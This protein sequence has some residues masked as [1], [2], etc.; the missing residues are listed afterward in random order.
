MVSMT[1]LN[2]GLVREQFEKHTQSTF[3]SLL[4]QPD[5]ADVTLV[6]EDEKQIEAHKVILGAGSDFF[7]GLFL[8][9]PH[10]K[11]LL[12]LKVSHR[13]L[14]EVVNFLYL[15]EC[16]VGQHEVE[17]FLEMA[18]SLQ[19]SGL[20]ADIEDQFIDEREQQK[21][22]SVENTDKEQKFTENRVK[23]EN[24][25]KFGIEKEMKTE[26]CLEDQ[27][28]LC[29][30]CSK[31]LSTKQSLKNHMRSVHQS[32]K[33]DSD[34]LHYPSDEDE[35]MLF[36]DEKSMVSMYR[37]QQAHDKHNFAFRRIQAKTSGTN[38]YKCHSRTCPVRVATREG[39][40]L[41][42]RR[43]HNHQPMPDMI[44]VRRLEAEMMEEIL[45]DPSTAH[46]KLLMSSISDKILT[47][48]M[49][50]FASSFGSLE[51]KLKR[52]LTK[53]EELVVEDEPILI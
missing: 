9:N 12:F 24:A 32:P 17:K 5:F 1:G 44:K 31:T 27:K 14:Q 52:R 39:R 10:P 51:K 8:R 34:D 36:F 4:D 30:I 15:G 46:V 37:G 11:P 21:E 50:L 40:I 53:L 48:E 23:R 16:K 43:S 13:H 28:N 20:N 7:K 45:K 25:A 47:P 19:I 35:E 42:R 41:Y 18:K 26:P 33:K 49:A 6:S 29:S 2:L 38:Y 3:N 22:R